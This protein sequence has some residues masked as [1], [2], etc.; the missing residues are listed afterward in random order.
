MPSSGVVRLARARR[1]AREADIEFP[2][3]VN[4]VGREVSDGGGRRSINEAYDDQPDVSGYIATDYCDM[5]RADESE[6]GLREPTK[7]K[8]K[9]RDI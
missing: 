8:I 5:E 3:G 9:E 6:L 1:Q 2:K 7:Q 4:K